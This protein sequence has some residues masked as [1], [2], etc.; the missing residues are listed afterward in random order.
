MFQC[1]KIEAAFRT[2]QGAASVENFDYKSTPLKILHTLRLPLFS[3]SWNIGTNP[4][5]ITF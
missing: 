3:K 4:L 1:S 5:F 2:W